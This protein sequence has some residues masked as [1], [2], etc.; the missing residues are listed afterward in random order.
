M[1]ISFK[2]SQVSFIIPTTTDIEK[3]SEHFESFAETSED[4][5][6]FLAGL[7]LFDHPVWW[8]EPGFCQ[9]SIFDECVCGK[10]DLLSVLSE[11]KTSE[12]KKLAFN[13]HKKAM[14][15]AFQHYWSGDGLFS[16]KVLDVCTSCLTIGEDHIALVGYQA[17]QLA[18]EYGSA[19]SATELYLDNSVSSH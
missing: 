9:A 10:T 11:M 18:L 3:L 16:G 6:E 12:Q 15:E 2:N 14:T 1:S 5:W 8:V 13:I 7:E 4:D 19:I 17:E